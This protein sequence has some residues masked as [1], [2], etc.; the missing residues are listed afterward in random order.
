MSKVNE[1][2]V[3][4]KI[5]APNRPP[6]ESIIPL[7]GGLKSTIPGVTEFNPPYIVPFSPIDASVWKRR[8]YFPIGLLVKLKVLCE[9]A[10]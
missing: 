7:N 8:R 6:P 1:V 2:E 4:L 5:P 3:V 10:A 9:A